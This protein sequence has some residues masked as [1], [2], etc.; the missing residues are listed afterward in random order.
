MHKSERAWKYLAF[1]IGAM[2]FLTLVVALCLGIRQEREVKSYHV[3]P[4]PEV[5]EAEPSEENVELSE[6][7]F[8]PVPLTTQMPTG[9][10]K[11]YRPKSSAL[12][13]KMELPIADTR[14]KPY[15]KNTLSPDEPEPPEPIYGTV[16]VPE[17]AELVYL[18][19]FYVTGYDVCMECCGKVDG[20]TASGAQATVGRTVAAS[21]DFPFGTILYIEGIGARIVE[22]RGGIKTQHLDVV[23][24]DHPACYA[25]TGYYDVWEVVTNEMP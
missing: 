2:C 24:E 3:D 25:I 5:A 20:I 17:N 13:L 10:Y 9:A 8:A 16:E 21:S 22:D 11:T 1:L 19:E 6:E 4:T 18:G 15:T 14:E 12:S 23:C 7:I